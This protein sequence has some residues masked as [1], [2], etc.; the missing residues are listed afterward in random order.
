M[1]ILLN[2]LFLVTLCAAAYAAETRQLN[3]FILD[4]PLIPAGAI[5]KGGPPRDGI[6]S[7]DS[8]LFV[9]ASEASFLDPEDRVLGITQGGKS[10]AYPVK[11]LNWHE[12]VNDWL[13]QQPVV[14]TYCPL[15]GSGIAFSA[16]VGGRRLS[17]GVSGLLYNS[18]VLLYD[19]QTGSLWSQ[20]PILASYRRKLASVA[21]STIRTCTSDTGTLLN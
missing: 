6:P 7:I 9:A 3:G 21:C 11:I 5:E 2:I 15:C 17:F 10:K 20:I 8:P 13:N 16:M 1:R 14:V 4:E 19:R 18:D 12:I